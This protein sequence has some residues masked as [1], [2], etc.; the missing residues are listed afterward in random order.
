LNNGETR[1]E[2]DRPNDRHMVYAGVDH[3]LNQNL[4]VCVEYLN[5][6]LNVPEPLVP[7]SS[8]PNGSYMSV[9][10]NRAIFLNTQVSF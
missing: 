6:G 10:D 2:P 4:R 7:S 3:C 8:I 9:N 5:G 1:A